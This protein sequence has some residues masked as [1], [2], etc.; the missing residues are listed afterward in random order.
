[1]IFSLNGDLLDT[2]NIYKIGKVKENII[3]DAYYFTIHF[4]GRKKMKVK[5]DLNAPHVVA[6]C[7]KVEA[8]EKIERLH[9]RVSSFWTAHQLKVPS[10]TFE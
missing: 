4:F 5:I 7:D 10:F 8:R 2:N 1:M 9:S 3:G 6:V